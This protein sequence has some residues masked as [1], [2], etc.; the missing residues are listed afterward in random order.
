M[1][2]E[3][4]VPGHL[5]ALPFELHEYISSLL[6]FVSILDLIKAGRILRSIY[7]QIPYRHINLSN[8]PLRTTRLLRT[9][10]ERPDLALLVQTLDIDLSLCEVKLFFQDCTISPFHAPG[11]AAARNV[12]SLGISGICWLWGGDMSAIYDIV[13][14]LKLTSLRIPKWQPVDSSVPPPPFEDVAANLRAILQNQP[15]LQDLTLEDYAFERG[16]WFSMAIS[17]GSHPVDVMS[18]VIERSDVPSLHTLR[19]DAMTIASILLHAIGGPLESLEM[20]WNNVMYPGNQLL[21]RYSDMKEARLQIRRLHLSVVGPSLYT[22]LGLDFG[23]VLELFPRVKSLKVTA[24]SVSLA[25]SPEM[26]DDFIG[27]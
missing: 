8:Q 12:Q 22:A 7:E 25:Y 17:P 15:M 21:S 2:Q 18:H 26:L 27:K 6:P 16:V 19:G 14:K 1:T 24:S 10:A 13:A 23:R 20:Y 4:P 3:P 11:L 5:H 9:F